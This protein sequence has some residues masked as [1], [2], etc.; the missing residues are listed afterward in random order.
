MLANGTLNNISFILCEVRSERDFELC[1]TE[2]FFRIS[3]LKILTD[4]PSTHHRLQEAGFTGIKH[5][6]RY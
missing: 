2:N 1:R 6:E 4:K 5:Y 3:T